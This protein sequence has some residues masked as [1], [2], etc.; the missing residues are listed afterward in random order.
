MKKI[1]FQILGIVSILSIQIVAQKGGF[2]IDSESLFSPSRF[3]TS[4]NLLFSVALI[5]FVPFLI[6][7]TTCFT[8]IV[9]ILGMIRAAIGTAQ[10]PPNPVVVSLALFLTIFVMTPVFEGIYQDVLIPYNDGDIT[11]MQAFKDGGGK[12]KEF[13]LKHTSDKDLSLFIE[14]SRIPKPESSIDTP[15]YVVIPSFILSELKTAVQIGFI[16]YIPFVVIDLI[17][18]NVLLSLGMFMLSPA[19][20]STPFK[21][22]L[23]VLTDGWNLIVKGLLTSYLI[24]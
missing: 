11:Q 21:L 16:L 7:S 5:A 8:R 15:I 4:L 24:K 18:S 10:A 19:M 22:L 20:V 17:V 13:M 6:M 2:I 1:L 9:I 12:L 14:F 3:S 23:F